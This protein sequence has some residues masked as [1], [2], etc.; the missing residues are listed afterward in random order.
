[1]KGR[2]NTSRIFNRAWAVIA[3]LAALLLLF[4][5]VSGRLTWSWPGV[6]L[7]YAWIMC[8]LMFCC[9]LLA[10]AVI[11]ACKLYRWNRT[12]RVVNR[13]R[14]DFKL[15]IHGKMLDKTASMYNLRRK[16]GETDNDLRKRILKTIEGVRTT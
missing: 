10:N 4:C 11:L 15:L 5:K 6:A 9:V 13:I 14:K 8:S 1:M 16:P 2:N 3:T 7:G 12:R